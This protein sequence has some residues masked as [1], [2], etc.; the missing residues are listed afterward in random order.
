MKGK[1]P[2]C[3]ITNSDKEMRKSITIVFLDAHHKLCAWHLI[4]NVISNVA[5]L[6]FT[7]NFKKSMLGDYEIPVFQW[8]WFELVEEFGVQ[9]KQWIIDM[10]SK[11][12]MWAT[13]YK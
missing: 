7:M 2:L 5:N 3:V 11:R 9:D 8:K 13:T 10:Y 6:K 12:H 1:A 4:R